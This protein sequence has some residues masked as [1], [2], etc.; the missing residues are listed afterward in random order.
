M[1]R[2]TAAA[3]GQNLTGIMSDIGQMFDPRFRAQADQQRLTNEGL[4]LRNTGLGIDNQYAP[5]R[6]QSGIESNYASANANNAQAGKYN[7]ETENWKIRN[8]GLGDLYKSAGLTGFVKDFE[9]FNPNAYADGAQTSIGYG[10]RAK[11]GETSITTEEGER[12][13]AA[14]LQNS[15]NRINTAAAQFNVNLSPQQRDALISFDYNTGKGAN[16]LQRFGNDPEA[17]TSKMLEYRMSEGKVLPGLERRRAAEVDLFRSAIL[18]S[19]AGGGGDP[20]QLTNALNTARASDT[21][22]NAQTPD[23]VRIGQALMGVATPGFNTVAGTTDEAIRAGAPALRSDETIAAGNAQTDFLKAAFGL[24]GSSRRGD[25][26]MM[27][28]PKTAPQSF[29]DMSKVNEEAQASSFRV[30]GV[31][32]DEEGAPTEDP[33]APTRRVWSQSYANARQ[34]GMSPIEAEAA[35]N[36]HHFGTDVPEINSEDT[37][38]FGL[39]KDPKMPEVKN[40]EP[41]QVQASQA[42]GAPDP[43][44]IAQ[45]I[46]AIPSFYG[47]QIQTPQIA[48]SGVAA[49]GVEAPAQARE[50]VPPMLARQPEQPAKPVRASDQF[51]PVERSS[52]KKA[53]VAKEKEIAD[54]EADIADMVKR[55]ETREVSGPSGGFA[56]SIGGAFI[57]SRSVKLSDDGY[58]N[59]LDNLKKMEAKLEKLKGAG[60]QAGQPASGNQTIKRYNPATGTIE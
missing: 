54:L 38:R 50:E 42:F 31:P 26:S 32:V 35:A 28:V 34:A 33:Y 51:K 22:V 6:Y 13:L 12:R 29:G 25:G 2:Y 56:G 43:N 15:T 36:V 58:M 23:Q 53:R 5:E 57:P 60:N 44:Q 9:G 27:G 7:Q 55:L 4:A 40:V 3:L 30:F 1:D 49:T 14:E 37:F 24:G 59:T 11:P 10:T 16:L 19:V 39:G 17:L 18:S 21:I 52:E 20:Q 41:I 47:N 45:I 8:A 48:N 46:T